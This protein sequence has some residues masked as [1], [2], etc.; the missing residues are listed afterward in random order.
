MNYVMHIIDEISLLLKRFVCNLK[1][2]KSFNYFFSVPSQILRNLASSI[3]ISQNS[4]VR[5]SK[6]NFC[7]RDTADFI[8]H[9]NTRYFDIIYVISKPDGK[10]DSI[11]NLSSSTSP[12]LGRGIRTMHVFD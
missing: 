10:P 6:F 3:Q 9:Y 7:I 4:T 8:S 2:F 11:V 1:F 5:R 12:L